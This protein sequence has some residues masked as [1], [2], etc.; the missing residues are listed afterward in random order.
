MDYWLVL[1]LVSANPLVQAHKQKQAAEKH[2]NLYG[3]AEIEGMISAD[4]VTMKIEI[5]NETQKIPHIIICDTPEIE[6]EIIII[7]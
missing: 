1:E 4:P 5:C 2:L 6:Y 7:N 3:W